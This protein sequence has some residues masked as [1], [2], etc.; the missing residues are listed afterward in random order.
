MSTVGAVKSVL[1]ET[2]LR[3]SFLRAV[4]QIVVGTN[5]EE[6]IFFKLIFYFK[7]FDML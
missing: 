5:P 2:F 1:V 6:K 7:I 3:S 4:Q